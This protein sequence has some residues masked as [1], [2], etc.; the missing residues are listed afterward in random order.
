MSGVEGRRGEALPSKRDVGGG[1]R[2]MVNVA[3]VGAEGR[4]AKPHP[5]FNK[6]TAN[7]S[8]KRSSGKQELGTSSMK[9]CVLPISEGHE[10]FFC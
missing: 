3:V 7:A 6:K 2:V 10:F 9:P 4:R 1:D 5:A 8:G